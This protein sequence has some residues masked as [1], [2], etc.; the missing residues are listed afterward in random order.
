MNVVYLYI[1]VKQFET[2]AG[3]CLMRPSMLT[4]C[5]DLTYKYLLGTFLIFSLI[6]K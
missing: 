1:I 4:I 3:T 6:F 5:P 2:A